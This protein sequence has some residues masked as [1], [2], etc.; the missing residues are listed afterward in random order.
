M[1][2]IEKLVENKN[3]QI[4]ALLA[5]IAT[6][7]TALKIENITTTT[8]IIIKAINATAS[9]TITYYLIKYIIYFIIK[10]Y[11]KIRNMIYKIKTNKIK[12]NTTDITQETTNKIRVKIDNKQYAFKN[13]QELHNTILNM[14]TEPYTIK[15]IIRGDTE[16]IH[17]QIRNGIIIKN[18]NHIK[19]NTRDYI[20]TLTRIT[21]K[22]FK[23]ETNSQYL[24]IFMHK[25]KPINI[26]KTMP[27]AIQE[28]HKNKNIVIENI[29]Q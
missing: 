12:H 9:I 20:K 17:N 28:I 24:Y 14:Q 5:Y 22:K 21:R 19:E 27:E 10:G 18:S 3:I 23:T 26:I 4:T 15:H 29:Y 11:I 13:G 8:E 16:Y 1:K 25:T 2:N 6:L 7:S